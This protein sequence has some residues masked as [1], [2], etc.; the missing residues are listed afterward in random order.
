MGCLTN[1]ITYDNIVYPKNIVILC[2]YDSL[3]HIDF[4]TTHLISKS[5]ILNST[6]P[7]SHFL[8]H[9]RWSMKKME[10]GLDGRSILCQKLAICWLDVQKGF[11]RIWSENFKTDILYPMYYLVLFI[12]FKR[13]WPKYWCDYWGENF[14]IQCVAI[15]QLDFHEGCDWFW[16]GKFYLWN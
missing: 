14:V 16:N 1:M 9:T 15:S 6:F 10:G 13:N 11:D 7:S 2:H 3:C 5:K 4:Q 12:T 8:Y